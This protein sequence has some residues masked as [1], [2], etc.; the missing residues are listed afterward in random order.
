MRC[1]GKTAVGRELATL[2][3]REF[4]DLDDEVLAAAREGGAFDGVGAVFEGLGVAAFRA[5]EVRCLARSLERPAGQVAGRVVATG[6]GVVESAP[7]RRLLAGATCVWLR[8]PVE[9][10]RARMAAD[11]VARPALG[12]GDPLA[13]LGDLLERRTP[14]YRDLAAVEIATAAADARAVAR[15][16]AGSLA[17]LAER[18]EPS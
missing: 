3:E 13:E 5:L 8:A 15:G 9:V 16:I 7:A 10:L 2:L 14:W 18:A 1:A 17:R 12:G 11:P 4:V 6:G